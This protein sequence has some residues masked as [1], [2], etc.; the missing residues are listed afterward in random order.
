MEKIEFFKS[1]GLTEYESKTIASLLKSNHASPKQISE[2]SKVPQNKL[3]QIIK[4]F[5]SLGILAE[6]PDKN[7]QLVN[8]KNFIGNKIAEKENQLKFLKEN[9]K[10][11]NETKQKEGFSF[12]IIKGQIPTMNKIIELNKNAKKEIIGIQRNWKVWGNGLKTMSDSIKRGVNIRMIGVIDNETKKRAQEWKKTNA[13]IR[14]YNKK[15]GEFPLRFTIFDNKIARVTIGKPEISDTK[16]YITIIT[17]SKPLITT[18]RKQFLE[19]WK[20]SKI[21]S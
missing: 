10:K 4:K 11:I 6:L 9:S 12:Q 7:Y 3:Y 18:L 21:F 14:A 16:N 15:F 8:I 13:K 17:N 5:I 2:N 19:M 1:L 20:E